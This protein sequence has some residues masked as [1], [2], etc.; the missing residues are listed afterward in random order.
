M[1]IQAE[2]RRLLTREGVSLLFLFLSWP[3]CLVHRYWNVAKPK[4]VDWFIIK[5]HNPD[6][7]HFTQD[8]QWYLYDTGN[9]ISTLCILLSF[10]IIKHKTPS[11]RIALNGILCIS[12]IDIIHYWVCFKQN[13]LIITMEGLI[14]ILTASLITLRKW[15]KV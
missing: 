8:V 2:A 7:S 3:I 5:V 1:M 11:Y 15:K 13:E 4:R 9:M 12:I 6:G 14:M 10:I